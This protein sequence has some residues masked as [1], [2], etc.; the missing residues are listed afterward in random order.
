MNIIHFTHA[1]KIRFLS[2]Q[3]FIQH[4]N[5]SYSLYIYNKLIHESNL[6]RKI[7]L[8]KKRLKINKDWG[9]IFKRF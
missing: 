9:N 1:I 5:N 4:M 8:L 2:F 3:S 6:E 7:G